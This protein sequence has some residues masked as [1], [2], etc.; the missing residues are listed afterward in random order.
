MRRACCVLIDTHAEAKQHMPTTSHGCLGVVE[1]R[2][3]AH[4]TASVRALRPA[5]S[6]KL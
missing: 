2:A 3:P 6:C 1:L 5:R 4:C